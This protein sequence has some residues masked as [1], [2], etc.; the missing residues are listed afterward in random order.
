M[1]QYFCVRCE[2]CAARP[3]CNGHLAAAKSGEIPPRMPERGIAIA[4][5]WPIKLVLASYAL[6][7]AEASNEKSVA[8]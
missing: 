2:R 8:I 6:M 7:A 4:S 5:I 3:A 1:K